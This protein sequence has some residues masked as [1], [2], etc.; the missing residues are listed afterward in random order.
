MK[1]PNCNRKMKDKSYLLLETTEE[2]FDKEHLIKWV[3]KYKCKNCGLKIINGKIK[4][5]EKNNE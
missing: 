5:G 2:G 4:K 3:E 1:C